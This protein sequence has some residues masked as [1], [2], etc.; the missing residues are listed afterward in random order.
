MPTKLYAGTPNVGDPYASLFNISAP[1]YGSDLYVNS[2]N[3]YIGLYL[4]H[5]ISPARIIG[6]T[7]NSSRIP[8]KFVGLVK[9]E[10]QKTFYDYN[11]TVLSIRNYSISGGVINVTLNYTIPGYLQKYMGSG[12]F[13][14]PF[15][16][17]AVMYKSGTCIP[18]YPPTGAGE[19]E[20]V[21]SGP[22]SQKMA[23]LTSGTVT[24][25]FPDENGS[26]VLYYYLGSFSLASPYYYVGTFN[27]GVL[28]VNPITSL[29]SSL[30]VNEYQQTNSVLSPSFLMVSQPNVSVSDGIATEMNYTAFVAYPT[31][32]LFNRT[33]TESILSH[34][35]IH[36]IPMINE[37]FNGLTMM[38]RAQSSINLANNDS[39]D[40]QLQTPIN[41]TYH[42]TIITSGSINLAGIGNIKGSSQFNLRING[43]YVLHIHSFTNSNV[44]MQ[45]FQNDSFGSGKL[46]S[47][48]EISPVHYSASIAWNGTV[49]IVL[50][51][52]Y[53]PLW[54]LTYNGK[55]Y[56]PIPL[57]GGAATGYVLKSPSGNISIFFRMQTPLELGYAVSGI[58]AVTAAALIY[59]YR[60]R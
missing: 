57:Y 32:Y 46:Y 47:V 18:V 28:R 16:I 48:R 7:A 4:A 34:Y 44:T 21:D 11:S 40:L 59:I 10:L 54:V 26:I 9:Y 60:R 29:N 30:S 45:I 22:S 55:E 35:D 33:G 49:L 15:S 58:F 24:F 31:T 19:F 56:T 14:P 51:Q 42:V 27:D 23:D 12:R 17:G 20:M 43:S 39:I 52:Q 38:H 13:G 3:P 8:S 53:S 25:T 36:I 2:E 41:G 50:P 5:L 37:S 6:G 1:I